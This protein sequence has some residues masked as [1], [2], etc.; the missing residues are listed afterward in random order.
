MLF[1]PDS[2]YSRKLPLGPCPWSRA[3]FQDGALVVTAF[4]A[5][6]DMF[7]SKRSLKMCLAFLEAD[8]TGLTGIG[9]MPTIVPRLY[10]IDS[11]LSLPSL[12]W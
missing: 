12:V 9:T 5:V 6:V 1:H 11:P 4:S 8:C 7:V 2:Q 10:Q 3:L